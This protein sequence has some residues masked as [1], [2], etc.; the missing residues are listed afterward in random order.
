MWRQGQRGPLYRGLTV[1]QKIQRC[2]EG[3][4]CWILQRL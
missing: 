4:F 1:R 2:R 3:A